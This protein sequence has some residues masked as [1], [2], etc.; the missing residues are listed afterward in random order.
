MFLYFHVIFLNVKEIIMIVP[1]TNYRFAGIVYEHRRDS[2]R[3]TNQIIRII[4]LMRDAKW[5][6]LKEISELT[7][8]PEAS[9]SAQ[10]RHLRKERFGSHIVNKRL[11][12]N[13]PNTWEY[14][15]LWNDNGRTKDIGNP[16]GSRLETQESIQ[17]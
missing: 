9:V 12:D 2:L 8:D 14:Q 6:T 10:L 7:G 16:W 11:R 15:L 13:W 1:N 5:R 4:C 17:N 3:L